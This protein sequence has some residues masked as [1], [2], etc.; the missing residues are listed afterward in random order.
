MSGLPN[1][2]PV[3]AQNDEPLPTPPAV[4]PR[5]SLP[6]PPPR[7]ATA[8]EEFELLRHQHALDMAEALTREAAL[9]YQLALAMSGSAS[10]D[11]QPLMAEMS[12]RCQAFA[13]KLDQRNAE[14]EKLRQENGALY[15]K[16]QDSERDFQAYV[17]WAEDE[18]LAQQ[19]SLSRKQEELDAANAAVASLKAKLECEC[20]WS[21]WYRSQW[22]QEVNRGAGP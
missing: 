5:R 10:A 22:D 13:D 4:P 20:E 1:P 19:T 8:E 11:T 14:L 17:K 12:A 3:P 21:S 6:A 18:M 2:P 7:P 16:Y 9:R 15:K